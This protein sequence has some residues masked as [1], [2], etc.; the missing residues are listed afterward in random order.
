M[1]KATAPSRSRGRPRGFDRD[2]VLDRAMRLFWERGY[3][4]TSVSELTEIMGITPPTL[5]RFFGDKKRLFLEAVDRYQSGPG[6]F[7]IKAFTEEPTAE[8]SVRRLLMESL[9]SFSNPKGPKGCLVVLGATNCMVES[10]DIFKALAERRHAAVAAVRS[11][12]ASGRAD[13]ELAEGADIDALTGLIT[14]TLFG[15]AIKA[16]DGASRAS[17]R[18]IVDQTM[19]AWPG[20]HKEGG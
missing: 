5:Y 17:M 20:R 8:R 3:E 13:G 1:K 19:Q 16:R 6:C 11:R 18:K 9:V 2:E 14:A 15:L 12:I 4:A 10:D 7:A